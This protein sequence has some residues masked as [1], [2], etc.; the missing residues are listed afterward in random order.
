MSS[1]RQ[2]VVI[3]GT[4]NPGGKVLSG[5]PQGS[6]LGAILFILFI[7]DLPD[8]LVSFSRTAIFA[9]DTKCYNNICSQEDVTYL[10]HDLQSISNWAL[11]NEL[12]FQPVKC[13]NLR[14]F[15]KRNSIDRSYFLNDVQLKTVGTSRDLVFSSL[16]IYI[17]QHIL[18]LSSLRLIK[19][20][21]SSI[22]TT[23]A[24]YLLIYTQRTLYVCLVSSHLTYAY[25]KWSPTFSGSLYLMRTVPLT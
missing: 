1:R 11:R 5:V 24:I 17:R 3:N 21:V 14:I 2:R 8:C 13:E 15:R 7:N 18:I 23:L 10:Q 12:S 25:Q 22:E 6:V 9:D 16:R 4:F 20:L 19:C